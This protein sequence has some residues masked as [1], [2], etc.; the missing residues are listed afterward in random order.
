MGEYIGRITLP[1]DT[2]LF[3]VNNVFHK[4]IKESTTKENILKMMPEIYENVDAVEIIK[5]L[6]YSA[7]KALENLIEYTKTSN[8]IKRFYLHYEFVSSRYL[9][10]AMILTTRAKYSE[11]I[12]TLNPGVLEKLEKLFTAEN[13]KIAERYG[14]IEELTTAML[15][16]YGVVEFEFFRNQICRFMS[17]II[18]KNEIIDLFMK[19]LNLNLFVNYCNINWINNNEIEEFITYLDEEFVDPADIATEQKGRGLNYKK[20]KKK[21]LLKREEYLWDDNAQKLLEFLYQDNHIFKY[22]L[23]RIMK[24]CELGENIWKELIEDFT[25]NDEEHVEEFMKLYMNWYNNSPQYVLCGYTPV[26]MIEK[27]RK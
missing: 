8:D 23:Q 14:R 2:M 3:V 10:E 13:R 20:F 21:D 7:Y 1:K 15:Y 17:E 11:Y 16:T 25:F 26:E 18:T 22:K 4:K 27:Y 24:K 9:E 5:L 19:R 12:Y 6:P